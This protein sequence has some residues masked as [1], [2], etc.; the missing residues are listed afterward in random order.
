MRTSVLAVV[1]CLVVVGCTKPNPEAC[2][3]TEA[4]CAAAGVDGIRPCDVGQACDPGM[5]VC[6]AKECDTSA[7]CG[8][9]APVCSLGLCVTGCRVDDDCA[10]VAGK[11]FCAADNVCVGCE[12]SDQCPAEAA[13]CD[14]EDRACRGC[15]LDSEC[16]SGVCLEADGI[17]AVE[18]NV[19][20]VAPVQVGNDVGTCTRSAPCATLPYAISKISPGRNVIHV[21]GGST[22]LS[23]TPVSIALSIYID[24]TRTA[25]IGSGS[26]VFDINGDGKRVTLSGLDISP[27]SGTAIALTGASLRLFDMKVTAPVSNTNGTL[28]V[29]L[30]SLGPATCMNGF[31]SL[32]NSAVSG[33][34]DSSGCQL[35]VAA[36]SFNDSSLRA[37]G[38]S[39]VFENNLAV[40]H[41]GLADFLS[42][43]GAASGSTV[44]FNT[45]VNTTSIASDGAAL[46]CD[47][48]V[49]ATSNIFAYNSGHPVQNAPNK[50][51]PA[52]SLFDST[53]VATQTGGVGSKVG[54]GSTF[55]VD[56]AAM[57]FHLA[58]TSPAKASAQA[59]LPVMF[60]LDGVARPNPAGS[61][62]DIG[63]F[64][65]P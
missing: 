52:F 58:P 26:T 2:C 24:G 8:A 42:V 47:Q 18:A 14:V 34:L 28:E 59:G 53:A 54:D 44:R 61:V 40:V 4:Q 51:L 16:A 50:C 3:V 41:N 46:A 64:E 37:D 65:A 25:V 10:D 22:V 13:Q 32:K 23:S 33:G 17:C 49:E 38:G 55:F 57:N 12:T 20:F 6:V 45:F 7:D 35:N 1:V 15:E 62:P 11:P 9:A 21:D 56:R 30:S 5:N 48:S 39:L 43:Q 19:L 63:A 36:N 60:D 27:G 31:F 29:L